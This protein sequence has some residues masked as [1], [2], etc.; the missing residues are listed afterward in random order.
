MMG[1]TCTLQAIS[2]FLQIL[3]PLS[4]GNIWTSMPIPPHISCSLP[5]CDPLCIDL[6]TKIGQICPRTASSNFKVS[7]KIPGNTSC[8]KEA[9]NWIPGPKI[10]QSDPDGCGPCLLPQEKS[11]CTTKGLGGRGFNAGGPIARRGHTMLT[12]TTPIRSRY[13][14]AT[15]L[16]VFGGIGRDNKFLNDVWF[17]CVD[18]CPPVSVGL[19]SY[20]KYGVGTSYPYCSPANCDWEEVNI[21]QDFQQW[22]EQK[23]QK[24]S[25]MLRRGIVPARPA[26][27]V[28]HT[29]VIAQVES[30]D[31]SGL[32]DIMTVYG[33]ISPNCTD[34]CA[35]IWNYDIMGNWWVI[36]YGEWWGVDNDWQR[37]W[38][39]NAYQVKIP[40]KRWGH[41]AVM[42]GD[43]MFVWGGHTNG[44]SAACCGYDY[45]LCNQP[46]RLLNIYPSSACAYLSDLWAVNLKTY[47]P[48]EV[49]QSLGKH[50][51]QSSTIGTGVARH[52]VDGNTNPVYSNSWNTSVTMTN[53]DPQAWWQVDLGGATYISSIKI[54]NREDRFSERLSN[55]YVLVS[56]DPLLSDRL[57]NVLEDP[58]VHK[59]HIK[60][61]DRSIVVYPAVYAQYVRIQLAGTNYLSLAEVEIWGYDPIQQWQHMEGIKRWTY[62]PASDAGYPYG[63]LGATATMISNKT[64]LMYGGFV[65][66]S[67]FFLDDFWTAMLPSKNFLEF[68]NPVI[69]TQI[70][71]ILQQPMN[72]QP[73]ARYA[74]TASYS[75][76]CSLGAAIEQSVMDGSLVLDSLDQGVL[77]PSVYPG[78]PTATDWCRGQVIFYG[79]G[80]AA[81][82]KASFIGYPDG[83][84]PDMWIYNVSSSVISQ[85]KYDITLPYPSSR[86]EHATAI[87]ADKLYL[88][89]GASTQCDGGI[90]GDF[91]HLNVSGPYSCP[92]LCSDH[93]VCEWGFCICDPGFKEIDCSGLACPKSA[94]EYSY[95][96]HRL[97]CVE[98]SGR[99]FCNRNGTCTCNAGYKGEACEVL[100][101][102]GECSGHGTCK[103]GG[104]C[105]CDADFGGADCF[106]AYCPKNC[107]TWNNGYD[108]G[109]QGDCV[110][111]RSPPCCGVEP[112]CI[113]VQ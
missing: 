12:Y 32:K 53:A 104:V 15:V 52:A 78:S 9:K 19:I 66:E 90:C 41:I 2:V 92:N 5:L 83:L 85:F 100:S 31:G 87:H 79:G 70:S 3:L 89:G 27:R 8:L 72:F 86:R 21:L 96:H 77:Q 48:Y 47:V 103:L 76:V 112:Y 25:S 82:R 61:V 49:L 108:S 35:D 113:K 43:Y 46:N 34:Y 1:C 29:A 42:A 11:V 95:E 68:E 17:R 59:I 80:T 63:R 110:V 23:D 38:D 20:D 4:A 109:T 67:P 28:G 88:F 58:E 56:L 57:Q 102:P 13:V 73:T 97:E 36:N 75:D 45:E 7:G 65:K 39:Y 74:H 22:F 14:G 111:V 69:W 98:C 18:K 54:F 40:Q 84:L 37:M 64:V 16:I 93:G 101:C 99:G 33:G 105:D 60:S 106:V 50:A 51:T 71:P 55:F 94:C 62:L 44:S 10:S 26:G 91:W 6:E 30:V 81:L 24:A 107:T